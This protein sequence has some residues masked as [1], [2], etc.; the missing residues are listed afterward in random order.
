MFTRSAIGGLLAVVALSKSISACGG[1]EVGAASSRSHTATPAAKDGT[2]AFIEAARD[3]VPVI[4]S[5]TDEDITRIGKNI[6]VDPKDLGLRTIFT[7]AR[8][9]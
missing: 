6:C 8:L 3:R 2:K 1:S 5:S 7:K 9:C 4:N